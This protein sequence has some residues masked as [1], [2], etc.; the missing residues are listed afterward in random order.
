MAD[1]IDFKQAMRGVRP[2]RKGATQAASKNR[3]PNSSLRKQIQDRARQSAAQLEPTDT[4]KIGLEHSGHTNPDGDDALYFLRSGVQKKMLRELKKGSRY[5][6]ENVVDLHGLTQSQAQNEID[7]ALAQ[8]E[9]SRLSCLLVI[10]GKGL[11]SENG[12]TLKHFT[13]RYLKTRPAVK[14][15]CAAQQRD[16]GNGALYV[17][18]KET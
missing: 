13:A 3:Q 12:A 2:L 11:H 15:Y 4:G 16:G 8:L 6:V 7:R 9:P 18:L 17:L 14:A 5:R 10:H 1:D